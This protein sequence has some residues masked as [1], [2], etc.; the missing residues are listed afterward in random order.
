MLDAGV[1]APS[2]RVDPEIT[3]SVSDEGW[4]AGVIELRRG[5]GQ[6]LVGV[7][8]LASLNDVA[9][10][11]E[12]T[13][14]LLHGAGLLLSIPGDVVHTPADPN[15]LAVTYPATGD[16]V[17]LVVRGRW[18]GRR[19]G[20]NAGYILIRRPDGREWCAVEVRRAGM[21]HSRLTIRGHAPEGGE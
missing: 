5:I 6:R 4:H 17:E 12:A 7:L 16:E 8:E 18:A 9:K 1:N 14:Q 19:D 15:A 20:T 2:L 13:G 21:A 3:L 11:H 10:L